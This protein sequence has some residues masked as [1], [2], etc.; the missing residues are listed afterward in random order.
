MEPL[1]D[2]IPQHPEAPHPYGCR[3]GTRV[4]SAECHPG[5]A[6]RGVLPRDPSRRVL[7]H[8]LTLPQ[9]QDDQALPQHVRFFK[10]GLRPRLRGH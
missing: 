7:H 10:E 4:P 6:Q 3:I 8:R 2:Y 5:P 1:Q 9:R